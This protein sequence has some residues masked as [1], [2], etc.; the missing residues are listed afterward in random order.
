M[1]DVADRSGD[2]TRQVDRFDQR[3]AQLARSALVTLSELG[4]ARTSLR[5]IAQ[6]SEFS[7]GV[8]H[9][10][11]R[12]KVELI[13]YCVKQYKTECVTRYDRIAETAKTADEL[14]LAFG[15]AMAATLCEDAPLHR[16]W[17][18]L[19]NQSLFEKVFRADVL[20]IDE[21]LERM[22]WRIV[23]RYAEL[24]GRPLD[25]APSTVYALFDGLFQQGLLKH[26]AGRED[27]ARCLRHSV[28]Q[29]LERIF[30]T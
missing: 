22:I 29:V 12:D 10:Y 3:R 1:T 23:S 21:T 18:D 20:A 13:T 28:E 11:F 16:L 4:Y 5:E 19:R 14:K 24:R 26:L 30:T 6:N 27:A 2:Q 9:Y 8:L 7:H 17:Y 25:L 15:A